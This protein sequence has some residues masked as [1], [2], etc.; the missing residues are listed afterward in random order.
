MWFLLTPHHNLPHNSTA[1]GSVLLTSPAALACGNHFHRSGD[2]AAGVRDTP[3]PPLSTRGREVPTANIQ[4]VSMG[5]SHTAV[6]GPNK[7]YI[8]TISKSS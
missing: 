1:V 6:L 2:L 7:A 8:D 4:N 3:P 5:Q